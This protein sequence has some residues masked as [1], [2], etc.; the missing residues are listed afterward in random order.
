MMKFSNYF[1]NW[2]YGE[3]GYYTTYSSIGKEGDFFTSVSTSKFFGGSIGKKIV[4][5]IN[6][7]KL[8]ENCTFLEI[9]AHHGY[10]FADIVQFIYT[11]KP[12][13]LETM[14]FAS[15]ERFPHLREQQQNYLFDSFGDAITID[16]YNDIS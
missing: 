15:V 4:D 6:E 3:Q 1:N 9:G 8:P 14:R 7:G 10:L 13:L 2:L 11:F 5:T 16:F 12:K